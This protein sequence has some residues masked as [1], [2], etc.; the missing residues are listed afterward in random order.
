MATHQEKNI[1]DLKRQRWRRMPKAKLVLCLPG[2]VNT[3]ALLTWRELPF[4][5]TAKDGMWPLKVEWQTKVDWKQQP[6]KPF[7]ELLVWERGRPKGRRKGLLMVKP[8][9]FQDLAKG[10]TS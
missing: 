7:P 6:G 8:V 4:A 5:R 1:R 3:L 2:T 9:M 10:T